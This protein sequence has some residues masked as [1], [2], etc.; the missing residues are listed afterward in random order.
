MK[1][2]EILYFEKLMDVGRNEDLSSSFKVLHGGLEENK[3]Q[4]FIKNMSF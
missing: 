2:E 3:L 4:F 1:I